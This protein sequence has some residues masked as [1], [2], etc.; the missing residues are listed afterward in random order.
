MEAQK[1]SFFLLLLLSAAL[2]P[3]SLIS[4]KEL[5]NSNDKK[6]L[7]QIK[8]DLG[9]PYALASWLSNTDCCTWYAVT[10]N[11]NNRINQILVQYDNKLTSTIPSAVADLPYL[12]LIFFHKL[13]HLTGTIPESITKLTRLTQLWITW[14]NVTGFPDFISKIPTLTYINLSFNNLTGTIPPSLSVLNNVNY[15]DL[16][17]NK[18][19]GPIPESFGSFKQASNFYLI[20]S[21]NELSGSIP[22][23]LTKLTLQNFNVS[24]NKLCGHIPQGGSLQRYTE[25]EYLHNE[26]LCGSPLLLAC[27]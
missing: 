3:P 21:H 14:T 13:P 12:E 23:S 5:C 11:S 8:A 19:T 22:K 27:K 25:Y 2:P 18:L 1:L 24:N 9:N 7:L 17:R 26:C 10:C 15:V 6:V 20:L 16:S 4:A